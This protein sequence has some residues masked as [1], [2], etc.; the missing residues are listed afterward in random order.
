M[1]WNKAAKYLRVKRK[2]IPGHVGR[3]CEL[4]KNLGEF[5]GTFTTDVERQSSFYRHKYL[6]AIADLEIVSFI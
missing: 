5:I 4:L 3:F 6:Q 2:R 1:F